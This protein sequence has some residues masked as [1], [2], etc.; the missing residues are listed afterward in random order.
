MIPELAPI[1][2]IYYTE[3]ELIEIIL[4]YTNRD[5]LM[6]RK[7]KAERL[8]RKYFSK[9]SIMKLFLKQILS[10]QVNRIETTKHI[11]GTE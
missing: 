4:K 7:S 1:V 6:N 11:V 3:S 9:E 5:F 10:E 8:S 2:D